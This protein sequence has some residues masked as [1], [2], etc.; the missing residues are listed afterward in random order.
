VKFSALG[1]FNIYLFDG[2]HTSQDQ[3]DGIMLALEAL[4]DE[5]IL[6]VDDWNWK[7]VRDGTIQAI[8]DSCLSVLFRVDVRSTLNDT[9]PGEQGLPTDQ[10]SDWHNGYFFAVLRKQKAI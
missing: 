1:K 6:I 5:F 10:N 4:E 3:Y 9:H 2:P 8:E 7:N